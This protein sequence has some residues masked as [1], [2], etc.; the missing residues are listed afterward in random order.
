MSSVIGQFAS[1][2]G[3]QAANTLKTKNMRQFVWYDYSIVEKARIQI[4]KSDT[5]I[6]TVVPGT[7]DSLSLDVELPVQINPSEFSFSHQYGVTS[8]INNLK[9]AGTLAKGYV[10]Q[11]FG[12]IDRSSCEIPLI[13]DIYDEY[14]ARTLNGTTAENFSLFDPEATSLPTLIEKAK[15]GERYARFIWGDIKKFGLLTG[16]SVRYTAFSPWGQALKAEATLSLTEHP[17]ADAYKIS[18]QGAA[19]YT[20]VST[21]KQVLNGVKNVFR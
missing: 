12:G 15:S 6:G 10:L 17:A 13:Y 16:I 2:A 5:L 14:N 7:D 3:N 4:I 11:S 21:G 8:T 1:A 18:V 9:E 19:D 20:V